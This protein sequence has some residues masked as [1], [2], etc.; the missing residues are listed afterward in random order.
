M[1][2]I[3]NLTLLVERIGRSS[4]GIA[5]VCH[6]NGIERLRARIVTAMMSLETREAV[7]FPQ[8]LRDVIEY[9]R[10]RTTDASVRP[11]R[12]WDGPRRACCRCA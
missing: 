5:I 8:A 9:Y 7:P 2:D 4:L 1:G 3:I 12:Y 11:A 10:Q 6:Q